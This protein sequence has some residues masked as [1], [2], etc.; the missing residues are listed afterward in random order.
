MDESDVEKGVDG[1][2]DVFWCTVSH[3]LVVVAVS[4]RDLAQALGR[5][6]PA[7]TGIVLPFLMPLLL[8]MRIVLRL[9]SILGSKRTS[10]S[11]DVAC[12]F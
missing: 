4:A 6:G 3:T 10:K 12:P 2:V 8:A 9:E 7:S 5:A 11:T 1:G